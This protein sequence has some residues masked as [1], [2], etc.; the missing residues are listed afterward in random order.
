MFYCENCMLLCD[1]IYCP[2]CESKRLR[3]AKENDPVYILTRD[4]LWSGG[5]EETLK[6]NGIP[7]IKRGI[8]GAGITE[9]LGYT[10]ETFEFFVPFGAFEK[11]KEILGEILN[12]D[13]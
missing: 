1:G 5:I 12:S 2:K 13:F 6:E 4:A 9:R 8:R 7:C 11:S 3:E 10:S